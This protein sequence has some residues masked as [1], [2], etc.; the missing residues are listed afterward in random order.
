MPTTDPTTTPDP[1]YA[2]FTE[3]NDWEGETWHFYIPLAGNDRALERLAEL[4]EN[5]EEYALAREWYSETEVRILVANTETGYMAE[6]TRLHGLLAVPDDLDK[7]YKGQLVACMRQPED[8]P[9]MGHRLGAMIDAE[10][11]P[12]GRSWVEPKPGFVAEVD[13]AVAA[14]LS[15]PKAA[16]DD[17]DLPEGWQDAALAGIEGNPMAQTYAA[18]YA[19][20]EAA[21]VVKATLEGTAD[22]LV[23]ALGD[24]RSWAI[25]YRKTCLPS[26]MIRDHLSDVVD[27]ID[28]RM[29]AVK[30]EPI[31]FDD[32]ELPNRRDPM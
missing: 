15:D 24:L 32:A 8:E 7:I 2:R 4:I 3:E 18:G 23:E 14:F 27:E 11:S 25:E 28:R 22:A 9:P 21:G 13:D 6:H 17:D 1:L 26:Q 31:P 5:R 10:S 16:P 29:L 20:G 30:G 19:A 12:S